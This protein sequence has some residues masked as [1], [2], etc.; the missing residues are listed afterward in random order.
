MGNV[1]LS[2]DDRR[3]SSMPCLF[4]PLL[5]GLYEAEGG[6]GGGGNNEEKVR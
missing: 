4:L 1:L 6:R 3:P 5:W 2:L